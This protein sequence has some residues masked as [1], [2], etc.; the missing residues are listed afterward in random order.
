MTALPPAPVRLLLHFGKRDFPRLAQRFLVGARAAA[1]DVA[2][3]GKEIAED[4]GAEDGLS[5]DDALVLDDLPAFDRVG[6]R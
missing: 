2:N 3:A 5:R 6:G 1:D 4:I